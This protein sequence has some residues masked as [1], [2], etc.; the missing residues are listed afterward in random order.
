MNRIIRLG[1]TMVM[2]RILTPGDFGLLAMIFPIT[3]FINLFKDLGLSQATVQK[4]DV[5]HQQVSNLFWINVALSLLLTGIVCSL[6]PVIVYLYKDSRLF[7]PTV[8]LSAGFIFRGMS[9]QQFAILRRQMHFGKITCLNVAEIFVGSVVGVIS[10]I[11][12]AGMWSLVYMTLAFS[13]TSCVGA[14]MFC[15]WRP[16]LPI[17]ISKVRSMVAFGSNLTA[18]NAMNYWARN[19]DYIL[20]GKFWNPFLLGL[21]YKA[22]ELLLMPLRQ[23]TWPVSAVAIPTL[24]RLQDEPEQYRLYYYRAVNAI[25]FVSMPVIIAMAAL[26]NELIRIAL[27]NQWIDAVLIFRI[28]AFSG[29]LQPVLSTTGWV[30]ISLGYTKRM[31]YWGAISVPIFI[32]SFIVGLP[33]G[34]VG[35]A[36]SYTV[37]FIC[38]LA[39]PSLLFAFWRSPV[40]IS[41]FFDTIWRPLTI[42]LLMYPAIE[43]VRINLSSFNI[44]GRLFLSG[45]AGCMMF[46]L[47]VIC[48]PKA[49]RE[50]LNTIKILKMLRNK[51]S[52]KTGNSKL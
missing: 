2:A 19:F 39:L 41:E 45:A 31:M 49:R 47:I 3:G 37:C 12:G 32:A 21:Y 35:V 7:W 30:Y 8:V 34:P 43:L 29:L 50:A 51:C 9:A 11:A 33:W 38:I 6:A 18:Y 26:S 15:S 14:W 20:I 48:W 28:L 5:D 17:H 16:S 10:A 36:F 40:R 23:I 44:I 46:L 4:E 1:S 24:S 27:G 22:Y 52:E 25:A 13:V 42:S